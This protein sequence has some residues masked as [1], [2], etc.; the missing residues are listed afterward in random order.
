VAPDALT[1]AIVARVR[2]TDA[3]VATKFQTMEA[4]TAG[5]LA[6]PRFRTWLVAT[7]AAVALALAVAGIYGLMSFLTA[8]RAPEI[9]I[10]LALG[11]GRGGVLALVLGAASRS[12]QVL[13]EWTTSRM[14]AWPCSCWPSVPPQRSCQ[15]G[16]RHASTRWPYFECSY[17]VRVTSGSG[18]S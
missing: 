7:F 5:S 14:R 15:P 8:Q 10:R 17:E 2:N 18:N 12:S 3:E 9:G 11:A 6:T 13:R 4:V 1:A 16:A